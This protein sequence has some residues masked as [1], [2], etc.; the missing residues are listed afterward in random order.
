MLLSFND[1]QE[2]K[3]K[4]ILATQ[5]WLKK[6]IDPKS[7]QEI[8]HE[9]FKTSKT[10]TSS[11]CVLENYEDFPTNLG[12]PDWL[13]N[14][15]FTFNHYNS[16][17]FSGFGENYEEHFYPNFLKSCNVGVDYSLLFHQWE[18]MI[19]TEM[20]PKQ[21]QSTK[22]FTELINL[23]KNALAFKATDHKEWISLQ[24]EIDNY[25]QNV[26]EFTGVPK[27]VGLKEIEIFENLQSG[28][29]NHKEAYGYRRYRE[30]YGKII[31]NSGR[32]AYLSI[33]NHINKVDPYTTSAE[34][35]V[36]ALVEE[37]INNK[38]DIVNEQEFRK[39][40]WTQLIKRLI[41]MLKDWK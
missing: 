1:S 11:E 8:A 21:E 30:S 4:Y 25:L 14:L 24:R 10:F 3:E 38:V 40:V 41:V 18:L 9:L 13:G 35:I 5:D 27:K 39:N 6:K 16:K 22:Y 37:S 23:H 33:E 31:R 2:I 7:A 17:S 28:K 26:N 34:A 15:L 32:V 19:L 20:L 36:D 29:G 12:L